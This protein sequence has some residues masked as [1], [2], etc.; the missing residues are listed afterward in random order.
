MLYKNHNNLSEN[1]YVFLVKPDRKF[2]CRRCLS[3]YSSK[4]VFIKHKQRH[5]QQKITAIKPSNEFHLY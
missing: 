2:K 4:S 3:S 1:L 5:E